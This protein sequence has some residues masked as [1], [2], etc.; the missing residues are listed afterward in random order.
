MASKRMLD[1]ADVKYSQLETTV[2]E[3]T[4][5]FIPPEKKK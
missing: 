5:S 4:I 1:A 2:D 3:L